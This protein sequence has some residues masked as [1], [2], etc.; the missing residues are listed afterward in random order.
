LPLGPVVNIREKVVLHVAE[1][2]NLH[3]VDF[4]NVDSRHLSPGFVRISVVVQEFV[5]QHESNCEEPVFTSR[6]ALDG[7]IELL[8]TVDE[9]Q[10]QENN[11]LSHQSGGE[12]CGDPF[13]EASRRSRILAQFPGR[14]QRDRRIFDLLK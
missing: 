1:E 3:D 12:N 5:A 8:Q 11:I 10:C 13:A 4:S 6:L 2:F 7:G 9:K 14:L